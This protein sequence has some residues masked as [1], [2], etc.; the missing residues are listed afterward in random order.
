AALASALLPLIGE[1]AVFTQGDH[2][3][4]D[5]AYDPKD[6]ARTAPSYLD[7]GIRSELPILPLVRRG[8]ERVLAVGSGPSMVN[9][10]G[11]IPTAIQIGTRYI[12]VN[13]GA[14]TETEIDY[15]QRLAESM[16]LAEIDAC[17]SALDT[18]EGR[19]ACDDA[20]KSGEPFCNRFNVCHD[21]LQNA[22]TFVDGADYE[23]QR[24]AADKS[25]LSRRLEPFWKM[26]TIF[27]DET[28]V[29][30]LA[31]YDFRPSA[32]RNLFRAGAEA[33]RVRCLDIAGLLGILPTGRAP[34]AAELRDV[35]RWC[36][37]SMD[38]VKTT[39]DGR[40]PSDAAFV[41]QTCNDTVDL[42]KLA[43]YLDACP[44]DE[45]PQ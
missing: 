30:G 16:R 17:T 25:S 18:P 31:G 6:L 28:N 5:V 4:F 14:V 39:C 10:V 35:N 42:S 20:P 45:A 9:E 29:D 23:K 36:N 27:L 19:E 7:G 32:L 24:A 1:P 8:A 34:T 12:D 15:A 22:C 11:R 41:V 3:R 13:T 2:S 43:A 40:V 33:A 26:A 37:A 44:G 38:P 21:D